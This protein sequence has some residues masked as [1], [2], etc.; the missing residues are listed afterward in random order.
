M[1]KIVAGITVVCAMGAAMVAYGA[2]QNENGWMRQRA[3]GLMIRGVERDLGITDV[4]REQIK[5]ILKAEQPT[6]EALAAKVHE[7]QLQLQAQP[8]FDEAYVRSFAKQHE[9]TLEDVLVERQKVRSEIRAVLTPEQREKADQ[10]RAV[11][12]GRFT[13]RLARLGDQL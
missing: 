4:Q 10:M 9:S 1:K 3:S 13:D 12:Y 8:G 6:V 11:F 7:E 5:A 2:A